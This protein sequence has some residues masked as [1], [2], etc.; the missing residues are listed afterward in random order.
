MLDVVLPSIG[1]ATLVAAAL[2]LGRTWIQE[3]LTGSIRLDTERSLA[4]LKS[5][6]DQASQR[7]KD[8][9]LAGTAANA[10]VERELLEHR[11]NAVNRVWESVLSWQTVSVATMM[12]SVLS[13]DWLKENASHPGTKSTFEQLLKNTDHLNF[14]KKQNETELVRLFF[15]NKFGPYTR[16]ITAFFRLG[17]RKLLSWL[18]PA[19][20]MPKCYHDSTSVI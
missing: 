19:L 5:D 6:L 7:I 9:A 2:W 8:L 11:I 1:S 13:D 10:H 3:R 17:L 16:H 4:K 15:L 18:F 12:V 14:M 20:T